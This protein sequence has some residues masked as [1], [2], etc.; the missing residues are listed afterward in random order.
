MLLSVL[1]KNYIVDTGIHDSESR[2][3]QRLSINGLFIQD[4]TS[5]SQYTEQYVERHAQKKKKMASSEST[6]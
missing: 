4:N 5:I 3:L 6:S 2:V 1:A